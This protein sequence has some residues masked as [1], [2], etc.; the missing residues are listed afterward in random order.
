MGIEFNNP[1]N[2]EKEAERLRKQ[3]IDNFEASLVQTRA[4]IE[5][6]IS[7]GREVTGASTKPYS[8]AYKKRKKGAGAVDWRLSGQ[9]WRAIKA[10]VQV[11][12]RQII[13]TIGPDNSSR[14]PTSVGLVG[15]GSGRTTPIRT[16]MRG[17]IS[18]RPGL[19]GLSKAET[20]KLVK[21]IRDGIR[22]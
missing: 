15:K 11:K 12:G 21:N 8:A 5:R 7:K 20:K 6:R 3:V 14:V 10:R 2:A 13:G 22:L 18:D 17:L 19:W 9:L 16:I 4:D 1:F